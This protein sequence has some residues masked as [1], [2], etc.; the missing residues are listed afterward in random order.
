[1]INLA[2]VYILLKAWKAIAD[3]LGWNYDMGIKVL[4]Y[5]NHNIRSGERATS[6]NFIVADKS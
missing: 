4:V 2:S 3:F 6:E 5:F 1:M